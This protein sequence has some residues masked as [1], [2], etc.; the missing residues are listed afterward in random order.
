MTFIKVKG[1]WV[2]LYRAFDRHDCT[3]HFRLRAK[4]DMAAARA[5]FKNGD[6]NEVTIDKSGANKAAMGAI[7]LGMEVPIKVRQI[8]YINN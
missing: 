3:I 8:K 2:Y 7:N 5:F 6:P 1:R 4:I